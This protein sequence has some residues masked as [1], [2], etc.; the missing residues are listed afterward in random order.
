MRTH[1]LLYLYMVEKKAV[2][3]FYKTNNLVHVLINHQWSHSLKPN[4]RNKTSICKLRRNIIF[5]S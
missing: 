2:R 1:S 4:H 5:R 3:L